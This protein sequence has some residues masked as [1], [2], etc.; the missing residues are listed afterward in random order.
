M[1]NL[2]KAALI[3]TLALGLASPVIA[4]TAPSGMKDV[5]TSDNSMRTSKLIGAAVYNDDGDKIGSIIDVLVRSGAAEPV[6]IVSVGDFL[7]GGAKLVAFPIAKLQLDAGKAMMRG[8]SKLAIQ[9]MPG[10]DFNNGG[11]G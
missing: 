9:R 4:Q 10:Y 5:M 1:K 6:A 3:A 2:S 7:G 11:S 8:A